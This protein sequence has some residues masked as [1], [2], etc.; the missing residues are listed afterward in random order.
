MDQYKCFKATLTEEI[1]ETHFDHTM[2]KEEKVKKER[3]TTAWYTLD[4]PIN[5]GPDD[6]WGLPGLILEVNDGKMAMMCTK[7][8]INPKN[9][10][11]IDIPS[12]GKKVDAAT[13]EKISEE[14]AKEMM[15]RMGGGRKKGDGS[16]FS[17]RIGG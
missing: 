5:H 16:S 10:I 9:P 1:E 15:E 7:V 14:K 4:I 12:K 6:F 17:I 2:D 13:Y 3:V 8:V 11:T